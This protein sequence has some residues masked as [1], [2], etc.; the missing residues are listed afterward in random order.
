MQKIAII[1]ATK[2][3]FW[4][5]LIVYV[6]QKLIISL[7]SLCVYIYEY[8]QSTFLAKL[9]EKS[10]YALLNLISTTY[11]LDG[12]K[13]HGCNSTMKQ[14]LH[15]FSLFRSTLCDNYWSNPLLIF[16]GKLPYALMYITYMDSSLFYL[17]HF[18][19]IYL[20]HFILFTCFNV[21]CFACFI[22]LLVSF[23][24]VLLVSFCRISLQ[25]V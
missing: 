8:S 20:F 12:S 3:Q 2:K 13:W 18:V 23:G 22:L 1:M 14:N 24:C 4:K 5:C 9:E 17:F 7:I 15:S 25:T 16:N 21:S 11:M 19:V 10:M 6:Y